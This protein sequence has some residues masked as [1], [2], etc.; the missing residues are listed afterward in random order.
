MSRVNGVGGASAIAGGRAT[1]AAGGPGGFSVAAD[2]PAAEGVG[3]AQAVQPMGLIGMLAL[4]EAETETT[5]N[6]N[7]RRHG[8]AVLDA[9]QELQH[10]LLSPAGDG[11]E[12]A[13]LFA[14]A[15]ES[16]SVADPV[17]GQVLSAIRLRAKIELLRRGVEPG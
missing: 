14:L 5:G 2:S 17:L 15:R 11:Q 12:I 6:K 16:S 10:G 4:Q 9:L 13:R 7:G 3:R 1:K 8:F